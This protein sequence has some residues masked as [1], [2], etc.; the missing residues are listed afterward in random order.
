MPNFNKNEAWRITNPYMHNDPLRLMYHI[1]NI[2]HIW[3]R[4][5]HA[6]TMSEKKK[7]V[8]KLFTSTLLEAMAVIEV[9]NR[10]SF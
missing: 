4:G 6:L 5:I 8:E 10:Y 1:H 9:Q 7:T 3:S 2:K